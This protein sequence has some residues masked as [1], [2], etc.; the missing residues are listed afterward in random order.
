MIYTIFRKDK[1][2]HAKLTERLFVAETMMKKLHQ[3]N[4]SLEEENQRLV[5]KFNPS[6]IN[7]HI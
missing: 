3:R 6:I 1:L 4:K 5:L 2:H 7:I